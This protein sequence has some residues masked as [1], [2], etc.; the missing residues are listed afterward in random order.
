M[1]CCIYRRGVSGA[2]GLHEPHAVLYN[3]TNL[4]CCLLDYSNT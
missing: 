4:A 1:S 2:W 3:L